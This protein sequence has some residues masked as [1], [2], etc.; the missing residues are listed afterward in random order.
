[1]V[2][3]E[4]PGLVLSTPVVASKSLSPLLSTTMVASKFGRSSLKVGYL[5]QRFF[6]VP[7]CISLALD[8]SVGAKAFQGWENGEYSFQSFLSLPHQGCFHFQSTSEF[9]PKAE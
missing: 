1:V 5:L 4:G 8:G 9:A 2:E 3:S 6:R 7:G